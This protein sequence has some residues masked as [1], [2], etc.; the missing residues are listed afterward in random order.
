M[1]SA[2]IALACSALA[3]GASFSPYRR[4][5]LANASDSLR[6]AEALELSTYA[7]MYDAEPPAGA[8]ARRSLG[9]TPDAASAVLPEAVEVVLEPPH[10]QQWLPE[11]V[12]EDAAALC[13]WEPPE[14]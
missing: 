14:S 10:S 9:V 5:E 12:R 7:F 1:R 8:P 4:L 3:R 6:I 13:L 11:A 2:V